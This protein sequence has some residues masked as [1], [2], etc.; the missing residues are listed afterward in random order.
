MSYSPPPGVVVNL[1]F[2]TPWSDPDGAN[3]ILDPDDS[4]P[5]DS[6]LYTNLFSGP[7][8]FH[9]KSLLI[10]GT[11]QPDPNTTPTISSTDVLPALNLS[12]EDSIISSSVPYGETVVGRSMDIAI[13]NVIRSVTFETLLPIFTGSPLPLA[14][15]LQA[16]GGAFSQQDNGIVFSNTD[17]STERLYLEFQ[18]FPENDPVN[19]NTYGLENAV[20]IVGLDLTAGK[21]GKLNFTFSGNPNL[22]AYN[23]RIP[24]DFG[25]QKVQL[26][27]PLKKSNLLVAQLTDLETNTTRNF[28]FYKLQTDNFFGYD[29]ENLQVSSFELS[30][31]VV[32]NP[33]LALTVLLDTANEVASITP[34]FCLGRRY[35]LNLSLGTLNNPVIFEW[36]ELCLEDYKNLS[37]GE[38]V[39]VSIGFRNVGINSLTFSGTIE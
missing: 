4:K 18:R 21:L 8:K 37:V 35:K 7:E 3:L 2:I 24:V 28:C 31:R 22:P 15:W 9:E 36:S 19:K 5:D 30:E 33:V 1:D 34:E 6:E 38:Y 27:G 25:N 26:L 13:S 10:F 23:A 20:G 17:V 32:S 16:C 29:I 11:S 39:G 12:L 14:P